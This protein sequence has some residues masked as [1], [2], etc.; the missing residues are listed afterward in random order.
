M[1]EAT[2]ISVELANKACI[3]LLTASELTIESTMEPYTKTDLFAYN[4]ATATALRY[5][6][7]AFIGIMINTGA[8]HKS[9]ASYG[10]F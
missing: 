6:S 9:I 3:H 7:M 5:T 1:E 8:L 10:Q 2:S 4:T